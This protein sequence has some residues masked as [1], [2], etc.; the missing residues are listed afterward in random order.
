MNDD[1]AIKVV[2]MLFGGYLAVHVIVS[3]YF[4]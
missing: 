3:F 1:L 2:L 4:I